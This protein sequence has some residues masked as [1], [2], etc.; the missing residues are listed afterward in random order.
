VL[1]VEDEDGLREALTITLRRAGYQVLEADSCAEGLSTLDR[2]AINVV[3]TDLAMEH[4]QSGMEV[5]RH[6]RQYAP[7]TEVIVMTAFGTIEN[8][9]ECIRSG[10][11]HYI[12]KPINSEELE[13]LVAKAVEHQRLVTENRNLRQRVQ[14]AYRFENIV[15]I[16]QAMKSVF[17]QVGRVA[18]IDATV[19]VNGETGTG[20]ELI[21]HAIH[22]LSPRSSRPFIVI[23]CGALPETLLE[24][25][26]FGHL[27]GAFTGATT[28]KKGLFE[29]ADGGSFFL[30][31]IS[32]AP[33]SIQVKLLR[34]IEEKETRRIG[35]TRSTRIDVRLI[36]ASNRDLQ[37]EVAAGRFREDLFYRLNVVS[38]RL[39]PL[40]E[41]RE[42]IP[43]L[44]QHF[45]QKYASK[46]A[47][48]TASIEPAAMR[49]LS[50]HDW[51]GNVRELENIIERAVA[52]GD[53]D[54]IRIVDLPPEFVGRVSGLPAGKI[55]AVVSLEDAE[56][57]F[58]LDAVKRCS[59]SL[60]Q[61]AKELEIGRTTLWR[62]LKRYGVQV[63]P[64]EGADFKE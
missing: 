56:R 61:A 15:G 11:F 21:A 62:R 50:A 47:R 29:E 49:L 18:A 4:P 55:S 16:S 48:S 13:M 43:I 38:L 19:L 27:K 41:R 33:L 42:D 30:D 35:D 57:E 9:V 12:T 24:T 8:A 1:L 20:K 36:A 2:N 34:V 32:A 44:A 53:A 10:A 25:E 26:L 3:V 52:L 40:R 45:L 37:A 6:A 51:P 31:E 23:N 63:G 17:E 46:F 39:P 58:I 64:G 22:N 14:E 28:N 5:L 59:G 7:D 60:A 54:R